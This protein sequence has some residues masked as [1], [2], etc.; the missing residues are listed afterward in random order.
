MDV[1]APSFSFADCA[2]NAGQVGG[3]RVYGTELFVKCFNAIGCGGHLWLLVGFDP[4]YTR[5]CGVVVCL[6]TFCTSASNAI[7]QRYG[8][9]MELGVAV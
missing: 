8:V 5:L 2:V 1:Q 6:I 4:G 9:L 7:E 3:F